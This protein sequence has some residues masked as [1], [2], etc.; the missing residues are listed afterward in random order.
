MKDLLGRTTVLGSAQVVAGGGAENF[1]VFGGTL[2]IRKTAA[3]EAIPRETHA[4]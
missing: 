1:L 4:G 3:K 2:S